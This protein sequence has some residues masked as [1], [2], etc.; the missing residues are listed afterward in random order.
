VPRFPI[1]PVETCRWLVVCERNLLRDEIRY[2]TRLP[3]VELGGV[4]FD[5]MLALSVPPAGEDRVM[6]IET[7]VALEGMTDHEQ[8]LWFLD[9]CE[10]R[11][12]QDHRDGDQLTPV[13]RVKLHRMRKRLRKMML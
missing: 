11:G 13:E 8:A 3:T 7:M 4:D 9:A 12:S 5:Q 1:D 6:L 10:R 2:R